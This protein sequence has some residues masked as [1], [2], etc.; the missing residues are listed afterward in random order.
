MPFDP[1][2]KKVL[3]KTRNEPKRPETNRNDPPKIMK[4]PKT[5]QIFKIE[6]IWNFLIA[7]IFQIL[8][9]YAQIWVSWAKRYQFSNLNQILLVPY[10]ENADFKS[11]ICF[12]KF[13][14]QILKFGRFGPKSIIL[15]KIFY[16]YPY[17][18]VVISIITFKHK[19][20]NVVIIGQNQSTH[21]GEIL[22]RCWFQEWD[23]FLIITSKKLNNRIAG[24]FGTKMYC[25]L[26]GIP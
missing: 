25:L 23:I 22:L 1:I 9:P 14:D 21:P 19:S 17:S 3:T 18:T 16:I 24:I 2:F 6:E 11:D 10:F 20:T 8:S 7:F 4:R 5:I 13:Q 26:H 12:R 15:K